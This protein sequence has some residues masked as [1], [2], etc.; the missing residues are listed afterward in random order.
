MK[1]EVF[2]AW[3]QNWDVAQAVAEGLKG[4]QYKAQVG[5]N[6]ADPHESSSYL[7]QEI[8]NQLERASRAIILAQSSTSAVSP[9]F[10]PNLMLEW[11]FLTARLLPAYLHVFL[12]GLKRSDLPSDLH[13]TWSTEIAL[14]DT[15]AMAQEIVKVFTAQV[16]QASV[17]PSKILITWPTSRAWIERQ[18]NGSTAPDYLMLAG[19][20]LH[21]VQP[22]FY[23]G[24]LDFVR[25]ALQISS[26][27][28]D[29]PPELT[30]SI[31]ISS[32][33]CRYNLGEETGGTFTTLRAI[34]DTLEPEL[35]GIEPCLLK[36]WLEVLRL[37]FL[38]LCYWKIASMTPA[39][40]AA[41]QYRER[42]KSTLQSAYA[43][44]QSLGRADELAWQLWKG[45]ILRNLGR[46][47]AELACDSE[48]K[49]YLMGALNARRR[50]YGYL[51]AA[52]A[53]AMLLAQN[54]LEISAVEIDLLTYGYT[55][56]GARLEEI[57]EILKEHR[58]RSGAFGMWTLAVAGAREV[59]QK[60]G[61]D[62]LFRTLESQGRQ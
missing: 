10:R 3:G 61:R 2:V 35:E 59:C 5:G 45:Y 19:A 32:A 33:A 15:A 46:I 29:I 40:T 6:D 24:E 27:L 57:I 38:G 20:L 55:E 31:R 12:I 51:E 4:E 22:A 17:A 16:R 53:S 52:N 9:A 11:G 47:C 39:E 37:D 41:P 50:A 42:A 44:L 26:T 13:G 43:Q 48:A 49:E 62:D 25:E 7:G 36:D 28:T 56:V 8:M 34:A 58:R 30:E 23:S 54:Y 21:S 14:S 1:G 18:L 60:L